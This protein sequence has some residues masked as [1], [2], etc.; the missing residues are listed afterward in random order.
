MKNQ[1]M[2]YQNISAEISD[3]TVDRQVQ[4]VKEIEQDLPFLAKI[5][6]DWGKN[7]DDGVFFA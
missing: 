7:P 6:R 3:E 5:P 4:S 2:A 1:K